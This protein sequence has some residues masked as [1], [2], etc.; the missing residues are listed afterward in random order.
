M[1]AGDTL[2]RKV[3]TKTKIKDRALAWSQT[4]SGYQIYADALCLVPS[5]DSSTPAATGRI[6]SRYEWRT[7]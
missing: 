2:D 4:F 3:A 7:V 5:I 6:H 1:K